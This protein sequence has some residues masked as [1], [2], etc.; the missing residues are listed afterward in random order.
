MDS[1]ARPSLLRPAFAGWILLALVTLGYSAF[2]YHY[3]SPYAAGADSSGYLN[4]ARLLKEGRLTETVRTIPG[5]DPPEWNYFYHQPLG[6]VVQP[7]TALMAPLYPVGLPLHYAAAAMVVGLEKASRVVNA[8]NVLAAGLL[9][10]ALGRQLGLAKGWALAG[11]GVLWACPVWIFHSLQPL[12]DCVATT[13]TLAAVFCALRS[14]GQPRWALAAGAAFAMAVLVRPTSLLALVP[15]AVALGRPGRSWLLFALGG[16]P[17]AV[18][19]G[20]YNLQVYGGILHSGYTQGG[21]DP[22]S[23]FG[24]RFVRGNLQHFA[25]WIPRL[26]SWPVVMLAVL[27]LPWLFRHRARIAWLLLLWVAA[28]TGFYA[29]YYCAGETWWYLRFLLPA[30]PAVILAA[31]LAARRAADYL[32]GAARQLVPLAL[33]AV[34]LGL[35]ASLAMDLAVT[36]VRHNER[37]YWLAARWLDAQA[38]PGAILLGMQ[39]SGTIAFYNTQPLV[40]WDQINRTDFEFLQRAA[41]RQ[42]RPLYAP[43]FPFEKARLQERLG[44]EWLAIGQAGDVTIWR[45]AA[46]TPGA[47]R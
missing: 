45:L 46:A 27:G 33:L 41:A 21:E 15:V 38:P 7:G 24:L 39:L 32:R 40:R 25:A 42:H 9:L 19:L 2:I 22:W 10:Y 29:S 37:N 1:S 17:G 16:F 3:G 20:W 13:W 30:F 31:L 4:S 11:V 12:S 43:L 26:L 36:D 23:S 28:F 44:G 6:Y 18:G 34:C 14:R 35:Q 5:L 47:A 8:L